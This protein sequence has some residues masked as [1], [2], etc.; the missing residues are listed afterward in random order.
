MPDFGEITGQTL[1]DYLHS[2]L[3]RSTL[4]RLA[5]VGVDLTSDL[6]QPADQSDPEQSPL[7]GKTIVLTGTLEHHTRPELTEIL[8]RLGAKVSGSMSKKTDLLVAG[9]NAGS[10]LSK[11]QSLGLRSGTSRR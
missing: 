5:A 10:K 8:E 6:F 3:G 1:H 9:A 11:A 7:A 2:E 4:T